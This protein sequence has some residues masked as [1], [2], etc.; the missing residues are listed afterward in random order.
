[1]I[2]NQ[3]RA[4]YSKK[5]EWF[6]ISILDRRAFWQRFRI[7][8]F[9]CFV[10]CRVGQNGGPERCQRS[11]CALFFLLAVESCIILLRDKLLTLLWNMPPKGS[12]VHRMPST[13]KYSSS[14]SWICELGVRLMRD[15][16]LSD[17][18]TLRHCVVFSRHRIHLFQKV[19]TPR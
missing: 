13:E 11:R 5:I 17:P 9:P 4:Q 8:R 6:L 15:D 1:M 3:D 10:V 18:D 16:I 2:K 7:V 14:Q 19:K 12:L